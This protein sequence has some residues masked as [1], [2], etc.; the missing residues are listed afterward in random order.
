MIK[1]QKAGSTKDIHN[2]ATRKKHQQ[3]S[4]NLPNRKFHSDIKMNEKFNISYTNLPI[5]HQAAYRILSCSL[6]TPV[7]ISGIFKK[8]IILI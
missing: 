5:R 8:L 2:N 3:I 4:V 1:D 6:N 7:S